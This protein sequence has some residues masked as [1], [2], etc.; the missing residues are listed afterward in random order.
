MIEFP[1][2]AS[3]ASGEYSLGHGKTRDRDERI[4][5]IERKMLASS[6]PLVDQ[7][8][9]HRFAGD[10]YIRTVIN[11]AGSLVST[12]IHKTAHPFF[13]LRGLAIV[14]QDSGPPVVIQA[15]FAS[16]TMPGTRRVIQAVQEIEWVTV[17]AMTPQERDEPDQDKRIA[18]I[19]ERLI[20]HRELLPGKTSHELFLEGYIEQQRLAGSTIEELGQ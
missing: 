18:M 3:L 8:L 2:A 20:E 1:L 14:S 19:E 5:D 12:K 7:P 9:T 15:P 13:V 11:P 16:I 10:L 4:D 17:H 6:Y